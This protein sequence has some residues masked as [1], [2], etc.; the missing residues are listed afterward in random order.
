[1]KIV[2]VLVLLVAAVA[3][4]GAAAILG[5]VPAA[6][7]LNN[8]GLALATAAVVVDVAPVGA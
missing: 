3:C 6:A 8:I 5:A 2:L 4:F 1:M 7:R